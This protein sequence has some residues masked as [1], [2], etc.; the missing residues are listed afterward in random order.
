MESQD[1]A[2]G[3]PI[4]L[5]PIHCCCLLLCVSRKYTRFVGN[6]KRFWERSESRRPIRI[7]V[8]ARCRRTSGALASSRRSTKRRLAVVV[9]ETLV[10]G[11]F[12]DQFPHGA[13]DAG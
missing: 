12:A 8:R 13:V 2:Y 6:P 5:T 10:F 11:Q 4:Q 9:D 7:V 1:H 3:G